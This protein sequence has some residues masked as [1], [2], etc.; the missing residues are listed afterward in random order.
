MQTSKAVSAQ[1]VGMS[2][3][4]KSVTWNRKW[5]TEL[6]KRSS[7]NLDPCQRLEGK[8]MIFWACI[9]HS[10]KAKWRSAW[11]STSWR[12][13]IFLEKTSPK[14]QPHQ[15][16]T[17]CFTWETNRQIWRKREQTLSTAWSHPFFSSH[18]GAVWTYKQP[19]VSLALELAVLMKMIG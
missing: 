5:L 1:F 13:S 3:T 8:I 12:Q 2:M 18:D 4:T 6:L 7:Q 16:D 19:L 9:S 10:R 15:L 17:I 14:K 11:K